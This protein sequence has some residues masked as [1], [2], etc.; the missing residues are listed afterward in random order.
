V[1]GLDPTLAAHP[2]LSGSAAGSPALTLPKVSARSWSW[3][4][5]GAGAWTSG[6]AV[7][8]RSDATLDYTPQQA[9]EG[10]LQPVPD[11]EAAR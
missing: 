3:I 9:I 6:P 1:T 7:A 10:W 2:L 11:K 8:A 4:T 5:A